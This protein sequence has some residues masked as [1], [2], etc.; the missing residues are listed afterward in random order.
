MTLSVHKFLRPSTPEEWNVYHSIRRKVLFENRGK[1]G[2]Y[3]EGHPDEFKENHNPLL[4]F[5]DGEAIGIIV[6]IDKNPLA[7]FPP[8][9]DLFS[10]FL[11]FLF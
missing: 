1:F 10:P 4:L 6:E 7:I 2:V 11:Q 8:R 9:S 3:Q 5:F